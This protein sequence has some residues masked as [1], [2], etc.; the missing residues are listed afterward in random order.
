[1]LS[2]AKSRSALERE[3][4][5]SECPDTADAEASVVVE[6]DPLRHDCR[7]IE[8]HAV[9]QSRLS[10]SGVHAPNRRVVR[11]RVPGI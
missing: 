4:R 2:S 6:R 8:S 1:M 3:L 9:Q 7:S 5:R 10:P 11:Q